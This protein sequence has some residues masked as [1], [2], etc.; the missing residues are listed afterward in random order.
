M[1][2]ILNWIIVKTYSEPY[3]NSILVKALGKHNVCSAPQFSHLKNCSTSLLGLWEA[4]SN[5]GWSASTL[6]RLWRSGI[7]RHVLISPV[8]PCVKGKWAAG[9]PRTMRRSTGELLVVCVE[10]GRNRYWEA[11][12]DCSWCPQGIAACLSGFSY[13]CL[14]D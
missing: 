6:D 1:R 3:G 14:E 9:W 13:N 10:E 11:V 7:R 2:I 4:S 5:L 12:Y 8:S